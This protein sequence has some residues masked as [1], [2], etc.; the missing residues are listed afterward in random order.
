LRG[1]GPK[2]AQQ[3]LM[4]AT[5]RKHLKW[6][7]IVVIVLVTVA[8][9]VYMGPTSGMQSDPMASGVYGYVNGR[10]VNR[11]RFMEAYQEAR[12]QFF[13]Y[14]QVWPEDS[15]AAQEMFDAERQVAERLALMDKLEALRVHVDD[16]AVA[17]WIAQVFRDRETDR[18]STE[19]YRQF[20]DVGLRRGRISEAAF[21]QFARRE[22]GMR[23]LMELGGLSGSLIP[24]AEAKEQF[25][26]QN[27]QI[28]T[29]VALFSLADQLAAVSVTPEGLTNF[30]NQ[31]AAR[32][33][34]PDKIRVNYVQFALTNYHGRAE[35]E[36]AAEPN[37]ALRLETLYLQRGTNSFRDASG[38]VM[39]PEAAQEQL[40]AEMRDQ[41]ALAI[42]YRESTGFGEQLLARYEAEPDRA[43]HLETLATAQ[44]LPAGVT[45]PFARFERP[46]GLQVGTEFAQ[47]AFD[48]S[49]IQPMSLE[50]VVGQDGVYLM[51]LK[52][53]VPGYVPPLDQIRPQV[54]ADF[55][56]SEARRLAREAA[57]AFLDSATQALAEGQDF[58]SHA[59]AQGVAMARPPAFAMTTRSLP[60]LTADIDFRQLQTVALDLRAG[61]LSEVLETRDG[62]MITHVISREP[63]DESRVETELD[64]FL[65]SLR[66]QRRQEALSEWFRKELELA[67]VRGLPE[68]LRSSRRSDVPPF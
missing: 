25:R 61:E 12:I 16:K 31:E 23:H 4:F 60:G 51:T 59:E 40:R 39:T 48:L 41:S 28:H 45:E 15:P 65:I 17:Q 33:R 38:R 34:V 56:R 52:A 19:I 22:V 20:V 42:A 62:A 6:L 35:A 55:E 14:T 18:F 26:L 46:P 24:P 47:A 36:L 67:Q 3:R 5:I 21:R 10:P 66:Q 29:A 54:L 1:L 43:D 44:D 27:E 7:W 32:Y 64:A 63:V 2:Q 30:F 68:E 13:L 37:L 50:P 9:V 53:R 58:I 11:D 57:Q 8:F 49:P